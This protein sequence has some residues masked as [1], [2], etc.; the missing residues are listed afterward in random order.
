MEKIGGFVGDQS[1]RQSGVS[2]LEGTSANKN[3]SKGNGGK[4]K[5]QQAN[6]FASS[7]FSA[8]WTADDRSK[9]YFSKNHSRVVS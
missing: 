8:F 5:V 6:L 7:L 4:M 9:S 1:A 2:F 3:L